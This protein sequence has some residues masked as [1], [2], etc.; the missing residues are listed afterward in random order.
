[1]ISKNKIPKL[2][3]IVIS[4]H[5]NNNSPNVNWKKFVDLCELAKIQNT[6]I[7][8]TLHLRLN[9][10]LYLLTNKNKIL[11]R[12]PG[13]SFIVITKNQGVLIPTHKETEYGF[14]NMNDAKEYAKHTTTDNLKN[15]LICNYDELTIENSNQEYLTDQRIQEYPNLFY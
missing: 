13:D 5:K 15:I 4:D 1:M 3:E 12:L 6:T 7:S 9:Y 11:E 8:N 2:S 14:R 10:C